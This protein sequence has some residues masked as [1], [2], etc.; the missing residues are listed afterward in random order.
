[1]SS[2]AYCGLLFGQDRPYKGTERFKATLEIVCAWR[3]V[4]RRSRKLVCIQCQ[5]SQ[6][7]IKTIPYPW[8]AP[9]KSG[10][11]GGSRPVVS[12]Y[13]PPVPTSD[14]ISAPSCVHAA[15]LYETPRQP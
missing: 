8:H 6:I 4:V 9:E 2:L 10:L 1:M 11:V 12:G 5:S 3:R 13:F 14:W 15:R 7:N